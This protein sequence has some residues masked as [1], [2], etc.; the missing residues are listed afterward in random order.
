MH[1]SCA[2]P[3]SAAACGFLAVGSRGRLER[4]GRGGAACPC[5][6]SP[7]QRPLPDAARP[8]SPSPA[9]APQNDIIHET[10]TMKSYSHPNVLSLYASFVAGQDLY[11]I[12][13]FCSGGSVLHILKYGH[14]EVWG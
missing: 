3:R 2:R 8:P 9:P 14:P 5:P 4:I 13:P 10:H 1:A 12:T 7:F 6:V 11:M